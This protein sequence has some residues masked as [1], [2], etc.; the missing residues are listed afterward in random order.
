M[1]DCTVAGGFP[2]LRQGW[3]LLD[4]V[5]LP[6]HGGLIELAQTRGILRPFP[7]TTLAPD[8]GY[9]LAELITSGKV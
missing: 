5:S 4:A 7:F 1:N 8:A 9:R 6:V 3:A 2:W